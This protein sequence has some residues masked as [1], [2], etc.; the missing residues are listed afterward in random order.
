M[1]LGQ[2]G[3]PRTNLLYMS[4]TSS[5]T[6]GGTGTIVFAGDQSI[7]TS[8]INNNLTQFGNNTLTIGPG[9]KLDIQSSGRI[10][11]N[12]VTCKTIFQGTMTVSGAGKRFIVNNT[13]ENQGTMRASNGGFIG[14]VMDKDSKIGN[15]VVDPGGLATVQAADVFNVEDRFFNV[16]TPLS[17]PQGGTLALSGRFNLNAPIDVS[18]DLIWEYSGPSPIAQVEAA[19]RAGYN[20]GVWNGTSGLRST[21]AASTPLT[22]LGFAES[23]DILGPNGGACGGTQVDSTAILVRCTRVGDANLDGQVNFDDYSRIDLGFNSHRTGWSNGDFNYD[24]AINFDDY[25]LIDLSF[26]SL[27]AGGRRITT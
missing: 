3:T 9:I 13:F 14:M 4:G 12:Y 17:V 22:A 26:N 7:F 6:L 18:G 24:G 20:G 1:R 10:Q 23:S 11:N 15:L 5:V 25:A 16:N 2:P 8:A 19:I 21:R 27:A